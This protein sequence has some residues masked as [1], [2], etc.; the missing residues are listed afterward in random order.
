MRTA[1]NGHR[2]WWRGRWWMP[3]FCLTL[4]VLILAA[5]ALG[6]HAGDGVFGLLLFIA[7]AGA[8]WFGRRSDTLQGLGGPGRDERWQAIDLRATA[9]AGGVLITVVIG[10]WLY[11][12]AGGGDG[13]PY[14]WL[15]AVTGLAY[16]AAVAVLRRRS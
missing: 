3:A 1:T 6:G 15:G 10:A 2:P 14:T 13:S 5:F 9:F 8:F 7:I 12:I 16:V 11:D 4:G